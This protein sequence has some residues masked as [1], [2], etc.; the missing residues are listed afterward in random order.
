VILWN[1]AI[2]YEGLP[3]VGPGERSYFSR[4]DGQVVIEPRLARRAALAY[5]NQYE[6]YQR[7]GDYALVQKKN[8]LFGLL[9]YAAY[10]LE[11]IDWGIGEQLVFKSHVTTG[12]RAR[13]ADV[14]E[15]STYPLYG[16]HF[17]FG[18]VFERPKCG[19]RQIVSRVQ[20]D[21]CVVVST[22]RRWGLDAVEDTLGSI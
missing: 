15:G 19:I 8:N 4:V 17:S 1:F 22:F 20:G 3:R 10:I 13:R 12:R 9:A 11:D 16:H 7:P 6:S 14:N 5:L 21:S 18:F 2:A